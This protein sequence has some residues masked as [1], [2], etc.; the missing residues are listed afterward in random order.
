MN[1]EAGSP[2]ERTKFFVFAAI[3]CPII[4]GTLLW[5]AFEA[6]ERPESVRC[7]DAPRNVTELM[8]NRPFLIMLAAY[9]LAGISSIIQ[10]SLIL[11][12]VPYVLQ[13]DNAEMFL[14]VYI[15]S[16]LVCLPLWLGAARRFEKKTVLIAAMLTMT[17]AH[18]IVFFLP[19][20][21]ETAYF[22]LIVMSGSPLGVMIA[23]PASM[24]GDVIDYGATISGQRQ[25]GL[26]I[27]VWSIIR[28]VAA[29]IG[30]SGAL[31]ALGYAGYQPNVAQS[32]TVVVTLRVLYALVPSAFSL[33]ACVVLMW[34]PITRAAHAK[35]MESLP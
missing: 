1:L 24:Q 8:Q 17:L 31:W 3:W 15:L 19:A 10:A 5:C 14:L 20:G 22:P 26:Y 13:S 4:V 12:F 21:A 28:K 35:I 9:T 16:G 11:Y 30:L 33:A 34:Y 27:G 32:P 18:V 25:E 7:K 6:R 23:I 29:A 2:A